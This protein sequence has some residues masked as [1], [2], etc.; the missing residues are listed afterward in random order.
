MIRSTGSSLSAARPSPRQMG[1]MIFAWR[2]A[3][4]VKSNAI[5]LARDAATVGIGAGQM[6]RVDSSEIAVKK[7]GERG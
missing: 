6:S 4:V 7:A 5:V 1:D 2:V 3:R